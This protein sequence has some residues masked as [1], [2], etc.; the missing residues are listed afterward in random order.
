MPIPPGAAL[1]A[2]GTDRQLY[3]HYRD[4]G[5]TDAQA[6]SHVEL[7]RQNQSAPSDVVPSQDLGSIGA[8]RLG[9]VEGL[10]G[11]AGG[12][13]GAAAGAPFGPIGIAGGGLLGGYVG[14]KA[15]RAIAGLT[16]LG[17]TQPETVPGDR[18]GVATRQA[19]GQ[20]AIGPMQDVLGQ[21]DA[22]VAAHPKSH[23]AGL[24]AGLLAGGMTAK[25]V[26]KLLPVELTTPPAPAP[27][28]PAQQVASRYGIP[29]EQVEGRLGAEA[30]AAPRAPVPYTTDPLETAAYTRRGGTPT[31][32]PPAFEEA[33]QAAKGKVG[34][35]GGHSYSGTYP[36][37]VPVVGSKQA[38]A[39]VRR[40]PFAELQQAY[41][42][43]SA[44]GAL[45]A[46]IDA[47]FK[48]RGIIF[49]PSIGVP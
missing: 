8:A 43:S 36:K 46:I 39:A 31:Q 20:R 25:S 49:T 17:V 42:N 9:A 12:M 45:R 24:L 41:N 3:D 33:T 32:L 14:D 22:T 15:T 27:P 7:R 40:L 19:T 5:L 11:T 2:G 18:F 38:I 47:E 34:G 10:G 35:V 23:L 16:A 26:R 4:L 29:V 6:R 44:P 1:Y 28:S 21:W 13:I 37:I 30:A 48:R